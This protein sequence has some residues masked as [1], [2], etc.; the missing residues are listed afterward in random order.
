MTDKKTDI[1]VTNG[2]Y[3]NFS[4]IE[5]LSILILVGLVFIFIV[6]V[7]QTRMSRA[8]LGDAITTIEMIG[9]KANEFKNNPLNGYYPIDISQLN[10]DKQIASDYF[11]YSIVSDDSTVVAETKPAFGK[12]G[13]FLVYSLPNK[14]FRV[15]KNDSDKISSKYINENW[16]P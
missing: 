1:P 11:K 12:E 6:P 4:L 10:I 8:H 3:S 5:L 15:G 2:N 14:Q 13:A 9:E 16:L 7:N